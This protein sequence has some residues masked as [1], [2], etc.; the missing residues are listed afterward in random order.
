[1]ITKSQQG[2]VPAGLLQ[3]V[4][5]LLPL[6]SQQGGHHRLVDL[7]GQSPLMD[8]QP[9]WSSS[10]QQSAAALPKTSNLIRLNLK[11]EKLK[12]LRQ[13]TTTTT[14]VK[15]APSLRLRLVGRKTGS[16]RLASSGPSTCKNALTDVNRGLET[17]FSF[18]HE[19]ATIFKRAVLRVE[20]TRQD[21]A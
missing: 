3:L 18:F 14:S 6:H 13:R 7:L 11:I 8:D 4:D 19:S 12:N 21:T 9:G 1:M 16:N 20:N 15:L 2:Q 5:K 17:L 10:C